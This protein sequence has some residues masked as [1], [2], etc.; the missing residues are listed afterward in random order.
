MKAFFATFAI[1]LSFLCGYATCNYAVTGQARLTAE[2]EKA[3]A[4]LSWPQ[5]GEEKVVGKKIGVE[6]VIS[7]DGDHF[8]YG[9]VVVDYEFNEDA[10]DSMI[11]ETKRSSLSLA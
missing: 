11:R 8:I 10:T 1:Q 6:R 7:V 5:A 9:L 2:M 4:K 3:V